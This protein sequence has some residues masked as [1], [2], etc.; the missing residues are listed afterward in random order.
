MKK[1]VTIVLEVES[2]NENAIK[3]DTI[4]ADLKSEITC[5]SNWYEFVSFKIKEV[6]EEKEKPKLS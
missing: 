3:D 1:L 2:Y 4:I 6:S 5:C